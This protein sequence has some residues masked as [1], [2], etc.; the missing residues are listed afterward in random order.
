MRRLIV[1]HLAIGFGQPVIIVRVVGRLPYAFE[2]DG[3][4]FLHVITHLLIVAGLAVG[5]RDG[6]IGGYAVGFPGKVPGSQVQRLLVVN[7]EKRVVTHLLKR[8]GN[9]AH[10]IGAVRIPGLGQRV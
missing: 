1:S 2:R 9:A 10:V 7:P 4:C 8:V 6:K 5:S 3:V